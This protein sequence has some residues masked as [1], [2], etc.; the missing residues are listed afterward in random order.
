MFGQ[1]A[2]FAALGG[3][4]GPNDLTTLSYAGNDLFVRERG[5]RPCPHGRGLPHLG[6]PV[7]DRARSTKL[8]LFG[9]IP[10]DRLTING[11][12][13][14]ARN[15]VSAAADQQYYTTLNSTLPQALA[16]LE[17]TSVRIRIFDVNTVFSRV[18]DNPATYGFIA[19]DCATILGCRT[20]PLAVQNQYAL[21]NAHP[22]DAFSLVLAR[23]INN[24]LTA[25]Y[26]I[27]VQADI[28]QSAAAA[29]QELIQLQLN[30]ERLRVL[31][32]QGPGQGPA[33]GRLSVYASG[34]YSGGGRSD[35]SG[36]YGGDWNAGGVS[37][38]A[39]YWATPNLLLG[40]AFN[41]SGPGSTLNTGTSKIS[42]DSYQFGGYASLNYPNW[43]LDGVLSGGF[44]NYKVQRAGVID[45]L[46][47]SPNGS[48][49]AVGGKGGYP[50]DVRPVQVGPI[51]G[52]SYARASVGSYTE[53]GDI[54]LA[55][56]RVQ[57]KA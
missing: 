30:T 20:A 36:A 12:S 44:N 5:R 10:F 6:R 49:F 28:A 56:G 1:I 52:L 53:T 11:T 15:G 23:Y 40:L 48:S 27:A 17:S 38:G 43:F 33:V 16:P 9:G 3:R 29:F 26:T 32:P 21:F 14:A 55:Q 18:L 13:L 51:V 2:E 19:G 41:Y 37:V 4:I 7:P 39:Q 22:S 57:A 8:R 45:T 47:G 31:G 50:F 34:D 42:L 25:P 24:L 54:V 46:T 35:R